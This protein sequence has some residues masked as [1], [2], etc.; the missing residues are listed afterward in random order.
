MQTVEFDLV[1]LLRVIFRK[2]FQLIDD[3]SGNS[4]IEN[5]LAPK[6]DPDR[7]VTYYTRTKEQDK[8]LGIC[9]QED[10]VKTERVSLS[11]HISE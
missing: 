11:L 9:E 4:F 10:M 3:P 6:A 1:R 8:A 5:L 7:E 2:S